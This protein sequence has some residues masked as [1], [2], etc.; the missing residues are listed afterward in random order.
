MNRPDLVCRNGA[1]GASTGWLLPGPGRF[2]VEFYPLTHRPAFPVLALTGPDVAT[3]RQGGWN[4]EHGFTRP[5][6]NPVIE[7]EMRSTLH[8]GAAVSVKSSSNT[9][10]VP[11]SALHLS[12]PT[13]F[14]S[15]AD[16]LRSALAAETAPWQTKSVDRTA[17]P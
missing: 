11:L 13:N 8:D 2:D 9:E 4:Q 6:P 16:R 7:V 10:W 12:N 1:D 14:M 17:T 3:T 5:Q 15:V